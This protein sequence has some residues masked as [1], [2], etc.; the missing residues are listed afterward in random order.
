MLNIVLIASSTFLWCLHW[1]SFL[2]CWS[3]NPCPHLKC[4]QLLATHW[5]QKRMCGGSSYCWLATCYSHTLQKALQRDFLCHCDTEAASSPTF[6]SFSYI[7]RIFRHNA[8]DDTIVCSTNVC[9]PTPYLQH[10]ASSVKLARA[11]GGMTWILSQNYPDLRASDVLHI[12]TTKVI[13]IV[14]YMY[15]WV[16]TCLCM[17]VCIDMLTTAF[18]LDAMR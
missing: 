5:G 16:Y 3:A 7:D 9:T 10:P 11:N 1:F 13:A 17:F 15:N 6:S 4:G 2:P 12:L 14:K 8:Y 18:S